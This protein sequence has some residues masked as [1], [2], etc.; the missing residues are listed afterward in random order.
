M[1]I[2]NDLNEVIGKR[3]KYIRKIKNKTLQQV[4]DESGLSVGY[5][6]NLER[7]VNSPTIDQLQNICS[8]LEVNITNI[9]SGEQTKPR[10]VI[11][12]GERKLLYIEEN[13]LVKYEL[14]AEGE[15]GLVEDGLLAKGGNDIEGICITIEEGVDYEKKNWGHVYNEI[16]I[17][18]GGR[19]CVEMVDTEYI[20]EEGDSIYIKKN[21]LHTFK[22]ASKGECVS[23]WFYIK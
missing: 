2:K 4:S 8:N 6:S 9:L 21:T 16:G 17:V 13:G 18:I 12:A 14:L 20:L 23:Y 15:N 19:M 5:L 11:K 22:N 1:T 7:G 3:I 10:S